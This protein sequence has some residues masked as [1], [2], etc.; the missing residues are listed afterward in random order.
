MSRS[1]E[2][3]NINVDGE[4]WQWKVV[5]TSDEC[6]FDRR[7]LRLYHRPSGVYQKIEF[8]PWDYPQGIQPHDVQRII[9]NGCII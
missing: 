4:V 6:N 7:E 8:R 3:R 2:S 1:K 9:K 5:D